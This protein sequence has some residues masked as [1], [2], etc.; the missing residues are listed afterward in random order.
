[1]LEKNYNELFKEFYFNTYFELLNKYNDILNN[2]KIYDVL[3]NYAK[4]FYDIF[5]DSNIPVIYNEYTFDRYHSVKIMMNSSSCYQFPWDLYILV[6]N[7]IK[8]PD[9]LLLKFN[10]NYR[11]F[12]MYLYEYIFTIRK[13][14]RPADV[15]ILQ[16]LSK[17]TFY[18]NSVLFYDKRRIAKFLK[19]D[20]STITKRMKY[21]AENKIFYDFYALNPFKLG[22]IIKMYLYKANEGQLHELLD[23]YT[24]VKLQLS[25]GNILHIVALT[26]AMEEQMTAVNTFLHEYTIKT[27]TINTNL[28]QLNAKKDESFTNVPRWES[29]KFYLKPH[30]IFD[31]SDNQE[32]YLHLLA[33][34]DEDENIKNNLVRVNKYSIDT[35]LDRLATV[36]DYLTRNFSPKTKFE[37]IAE[38]LGMNKQ[39]TIELFRFLITNKFGEVVIQT[40]YIDCN[41]RYFI[42]LKYTP[43]TETNQII[44][45]FR[46]NL[47]FLAYS[48]VF[49]ADQIITAFV[50]LPTYWAVN[51]TTYLHLLEEVNIKV[52]V[53]QVLAL[54]FDYN[55]NNY[56]KNDILTNLRLIW[57]PESFY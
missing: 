11:L 2:D 41:A 4:R 57:I 30:V 45:N 23:K 50:V 49:I 36:L 28:D 1:M 15:K 33:A 16:Y 54:R 31:C 10:F 53:N 9:E 34:A 22:F 29:E 26:N 24:L 19:V 20:E 56:N 13:K 3:K 6:K 12:F 51:F 7:N 39:D 48:H 46:K 32:W 47:L 17:Y 5:K 18:K 14:L 52:I 25:N 38:Q 27:I 43:N 37:D 44:E 42:I 40:K 8:V 35:R 21:L 55:V